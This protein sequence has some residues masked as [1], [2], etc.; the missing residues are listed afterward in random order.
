MPTVSTVGFVFISVIFTI[1]V[2]YLFEII[3][4]EFYYAVWLIENRKVE[5]RC[6]KLNNDEWTKPFRLKL[7]KKITSFTSLFPK[8]AD[9]CFTPVMTIFIGHRRKFEYLKSKF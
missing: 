5:I 9:F 2:I 6:L 7:D 3:R 8:V 4:D 1:E